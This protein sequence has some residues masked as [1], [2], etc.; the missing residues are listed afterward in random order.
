MFTIQ[1]AV[2]YINTLFRCDCCNYIQFFVIFRKNIF[3]KYV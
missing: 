2:F 1:N 3:N